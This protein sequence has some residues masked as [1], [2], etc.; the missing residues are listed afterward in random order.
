MHQGVGRLRFLHLVLQ[1]I[2]I[3][4]HQR[5][6]FKNVQIWIKYS[7]K[8][9]REHEIEV[10]GFKA[11]TFAKSFPLSGSQLS[12]NE[13]VALSLKTTPSFA[14]I[15][16]ANRIADYNIPLLLAYKQRTSVYS[17]HLSVE[18]RGFNKCHL[19]EYDGKYYTESYGREVQYYWRAFFIRN[20]I[21]NIHF[22]SRIQNLKIIRLDRER[23][24]ES[25]W[26]KGTNFDLT[27]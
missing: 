17:Y 26:L 10:V 4:P 20:E 9:Q 24:R 5:R 14:T 18:I 12:T 11:P 27:D 22:L 25:W 6:S 19:V 16:L 2:S 8:R 1:N 23:F 15:K 3:P 7:H 13:I 21:F